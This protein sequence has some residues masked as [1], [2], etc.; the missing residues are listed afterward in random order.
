MT[1]LTDSSPSSTGFA[2][3][4][5]HR[6][7]QAKALNQLSIYLIYVA[8][9]CFLG[10]GTL[11]SLPSLHDSSLVYGLFHYLPYALVGLGIPLNVFVAFVLYRY[12]LSQASMIG[13]CLVM[14]SALFVIS[15]YVALASWMGVAFLFRA[16]LTRF[17]KF[18]A[19]TANVNEL[20]HDQI[21]SNPPNSP[22]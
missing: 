3:L 7:H 18:L 13:L 17:F 5:L 22:D 4:A 16:N 12:R 10:F 1:I 20:T 9:V 14:S 21:Q 8:M 2:Q 11:A 19:Q 15:V 6:I